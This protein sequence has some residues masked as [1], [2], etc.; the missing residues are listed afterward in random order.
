MTLGAVLLESIC[1]NTEL[2]KWILGG[3]L[4]YHRY[5]YPKLYRPFEKWIL[6]DH[7]GDFSC[8]DHCPKHSDSLCDCLLLFFG[9]YVFG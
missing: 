8:A 4:V 7:R 2:Q 9:A 6:V 5:G 1:E 3:L